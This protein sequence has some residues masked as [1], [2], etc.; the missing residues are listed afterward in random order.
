[1]SGGD[2]VQRLGDVVER[3][4]EVDGHL[5]GAEGRP[6]DYVMLQLGVPL[7]QGD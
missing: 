1:V 3:G 7:S 4:V 5:A 2:D 6:T